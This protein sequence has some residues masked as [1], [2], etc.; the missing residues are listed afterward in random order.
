MAAPTIV[1]DLDGT[2]VDTAPDLVDTLNFIFARESLPPVPYAE[3]RTLIGGGAKAMLARGFKLE[4]H[5]LAPE[6][7][8]SLFTDFI[9]RYSAHIADRSQPFPGVAPALDALAANNFRLAVCTNKLEALSRR[10]LEA[11]GLEDSFVAIFGQDPF[12]VQ[13]PDPHVLLRTIEAVGGDV[14]RAVM[15]GDSETD[16]LT[17]RAAGVPIVAVDFGYSTRPVADYG[18]DRLIGDFKELPA[19]IAQITGAFAVRAGRH[20]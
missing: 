15:V 19:V 14:T 3:A 6:R 16:V 18:P 10:L 12:G 7:L 4:G 11:R 13:K 2:L 17:A 20:G 9:A 5:A 8:D 1:F